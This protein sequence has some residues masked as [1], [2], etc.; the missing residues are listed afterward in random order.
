MNQMP[1]PDK[2]PLDELTRAGVAI[3]EALTD[4]MVERFAVTGSN[5]MELLDRLNDESTN[6]AVHSLIDRLTEVHKAGALDTIFDMIMAVHA[7][8]NAMTDQMIERLVCFVEAAVDTVANEET[9]GFA[10]GAIGALR[11][12]AQ[13]TANE[14]VKA[15]WLGTAGLLGKPETQ[16]SLQFLLSFANKLQKHAEE[17]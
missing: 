8:R 4:Q 17:Q 16:R 7:V 14:P 2:L 10:Q 11:D 3:R 5:A 9:F 15:G 12:A 13:H 1:S 6:A